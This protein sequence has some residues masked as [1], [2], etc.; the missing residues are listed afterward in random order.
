MNQ[1]TKTI[2]MWALYAALFLAVILLQTVS[3]GR[4][5]FLGVKLNLMPIV[6]TCI[7]LWAGHE[8]GGLF[9]LIA[10]LI[11]SWTGA[12]DGAL[13]IVSFT[14]IGIFSGW[15]CDAVF[16]RRFL[17]ALFLSLAAVLLHE[18]ALFLLTHYLE[19]APLSMLIWVPAT[20]ILSLPAVPVLYLLAK[21]IGKAG[22]N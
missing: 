21:A 5:R 17:S 19:S 20:A 15:L 3:F 10:G 8:A 2:L 1:R 22:G 13:A 16:S 7:G 12:K 18:L 9:G 11:W 4:M 6:L 14:L